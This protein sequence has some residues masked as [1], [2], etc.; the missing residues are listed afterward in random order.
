MELRKFQKHIAVLVLLAF[1]AACMPGFNLTT[2]STQTPVVITATLAPL[3]TATSI[4]PSPVPPTQ[5]PP[6]IQP[7]SQGIDR[8]NIYLIAVGD[9]GVSGKLI[10]CS[11][12][13]VPVEMQITPT[14]GVLRA[15]LTELLKL[16]GKQYYGESGLYNALY[17]SNLT[18][19][20]VTIVN[21]E[22]QIYL[23]GALTLGGE[24]DNPRVEEQLTAIALQFSTV[25][26][27]SVY[28]NGTP[29]SKLL[30][31]KGQS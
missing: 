14:L 2:G 21:G 28:I 25:K 18:I 30:D 13:L 26:S 8:V 16:K 10:G 20:D 17:Q 31:L 12:S 23:Q 15:A 6:T 19:K 11:D 24:C 22:A 5:V 9:N 3:P 27:V 29:L 7:T 4:P 1:S